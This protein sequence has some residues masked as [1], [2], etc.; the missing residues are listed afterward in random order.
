M[1]SRPGDAVRALLEPILRWARARSRVALPFVCAVP[2]HGLAA[3]TDPRALPLG[4]P[5][6]APSPR[7]ADLLVIVG[8][9]AHKLAP[10]LQRIHAEMASPSQ[11][12]HVRAWLDEDL[13]ARSY[14]TVARLQDVV[15]VD[16]VLV[17]CP[18]T[19]AAVARALAALE[20]R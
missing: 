9:V 8:S 20:A 17:G 16:V 14:A 2:S 3:W 4:I 6:S 5:T 19:P 12:L 15:P 18:P 11:V 7:Q 10:A 13:V 1:G